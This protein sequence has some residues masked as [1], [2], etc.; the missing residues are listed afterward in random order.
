[1]YQGCPTHS[2]SS[3]RINQPDVQKGRFPLCLKS[4]IKTVD[5]KGGDHNW[6]S[7]YRSVT[8]LH[9]FSKMEE[10]PAASQL[11]NSSSGCKLN[12]SLCLVYNSCHSP[13]SA[14][15]GISTSPKSKVN[16]RKNSA[17]TRIDRFAA[18][19]TVD[20]DLSVKL[21]IRAAVDVKDL[22]LISAHFTGQIQSVLV[23]S[24][25]STEKMLEKFC[26]ALR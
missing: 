12:D 7:N 6:F 19:D 5:F 8:T 21:L 17:V 11:S 25:V 20:L 3:E 23:D 13:E 1:M 15:L 24:Y 18:F 16:Q 22:A 14:L 10:K 4:D 26:W 2:N 9:I